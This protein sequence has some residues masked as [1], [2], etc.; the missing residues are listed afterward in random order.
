[1]NN[2]T[3]TTIV[4]QITAFPLHPV[5]GDHEGEHQPDRRQPKQEHGGEPNV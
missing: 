3:V 5:A 1:M 4:I 2:N